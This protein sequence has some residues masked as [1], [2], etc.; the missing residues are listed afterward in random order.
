RGAYSYTTLQTKEAINE[1][2]KSEAETLFFAGEA[3]QEGTV[4]G[5]VEAALISGQKAAEKVLKSIN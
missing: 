5:T 2:L 4:T 3:L 1:M